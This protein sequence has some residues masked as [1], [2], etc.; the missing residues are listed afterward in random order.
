MLY[1]LLAVVLMAMDQRG[2]YV[3]R[4]RGMVEYLVE[5]VYHVVDWPVSVLR[6]AF[7]RMQTHRSLR[8]ANEGLRRKLMEQ[9]ADLQRLQTLVEENNRLRSLIEG[10]AGQTFDFQ[11][12]ELLNVDLDPFIHRVVIDRGSADGV[13][14]GQA[15]LDG[16][17]VMGQVEDVRRHSSTVR[18]ISDP[19]HGLPVQVNRTGL[20][21]IAYGT[22]ETGHLRLPNVPRQADVR[23]G[24]LV[25]TSGLG[26][27]FPSGYPVAT[28]S[29]I[30]RQEGETFLQVEATPLAA[31]DRG[32]EVLLIRA[33]DI[34][35]AQT[36]APE[37]SLAPA[38]Q[39]TSE[40]AKEEGAASEAP[41]SE[42]PVTEAPVTET[43]VTES[44]TP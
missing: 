27:R 1:G 30:R 3:P 29:L 17:G 5:P 40:A 32:R 41:S 36:T 15:I 24:D 43:P 8:E 25:V 39:T 42:I 21:T 31:L 22:G 13:E 37:T 4:I 11:F 34:L 28:V 35:P 18:L 23:E 14:P 38:T 2:H 33:V 6:S 12:A 19:S 20:R 10:A 9:Q 16:A 26:D 44:E 7:G